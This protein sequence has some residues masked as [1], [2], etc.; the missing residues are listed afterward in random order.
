MTC[1]PSRL[2]AWSF[3]AALAL[4]PLPAHGQACG[5]WTWA[6][7]LPQGIPLRYANA[8]QDTHSG[9]LHLGTVTTR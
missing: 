8:G 9:W 7:P 4:C 2:V 6:N 3:P 5:P 1:L